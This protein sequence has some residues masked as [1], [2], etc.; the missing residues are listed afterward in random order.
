MKVAAPTAATSAPV[1]GRSLV[2][3]CTRLTVAGRS[4]RPHNSGERREGCYLD[5][6][7]EKKRFSM[8]C[9]FSGDDQSATNRIAKSS[10]RREMR[11]VCGTPRT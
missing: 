9:R 7:F 11:K 5:A 6:S 3:I 1:A 2:R 4:V 8:S 10:P